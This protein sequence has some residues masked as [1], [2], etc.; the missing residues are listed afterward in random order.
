MCV[1]VCTCMCTCVCVLGMCTR[2]FTDSP[3][4]TARICQS[5]GQQHTGNTHLETGRRGVCSFHPLSRAE[6]TFQSE[7]A[8]EGQSV[9][10]R[11]KSQKVLKRAFLVCSMTVT[12]FLKA[13]L[14]HL[15]TCPSFLMD[16]VK[17][18]GGWSRGKSVCLT[19]LRPSA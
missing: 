8:R 13:E 4:S 15:Y 19:D 5:P 2:S 7:A 12:G 9:E 1:P 11:G 16:N 10:D 17:R 3:A 14:S 18:P 6:R